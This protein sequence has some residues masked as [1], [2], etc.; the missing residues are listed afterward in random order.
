M[1]ENKDHSSQLK[2]KLLT[3]PEKIFDDAFKKSPLRFSAQ[4]REEIKSIFRLF[5]L[6]PLPILFFAVLG[7]LFFESVDSMA[8]AREV[9]ATNIFFRIVPLWLLN[10]F[11][12]LFNGQNFRYMIAPF[13]AVVIVIIGGAAYVQDIYQLPR[14]TDGLHYVISSMFSLL[15]PKLK[16]DEGEKKIPEEEINLLDAIGGPGYV[17]IQP[18]HAVMFRNLRQPSKVSMSQAYFMLP[19]ET[20]GQ[21]ANLDD[22]HGHLDE[23]ETITKD[24]IMVTLKDIEFR[25]RILTDVYT[26]SLSAPYPYSEKS[27][28]QMAYNLSVT[29]EG[30]KPWHKTVQGKVLGA[31]QSYVNSHE[32]DY[33]TAPKE[34]G[35]DPRRNLKMELFNRGIKASLKAVGAELLWIDV[36]HVVIN[37]SEVDE[38]RINLWAEDWIGNAE[39]TRA[40]GDATRLA[41]QE[42]GRAEAQAEMVMSIAHALE[43][44]PTT[45]NT[46][47]N[48]RKVF[49]LRTAQ[50]LDAMGKDQN[51]DKGK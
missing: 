13:T 19:F 32:I 44:L 23:L 15:Y 45:E 8:L 40:Y 20:I 48:M 12:F 39:A 37:D 4:N 47:E 41:Y 42:L 24:G 31:I 3:E 43:D 9:Q 21:V 50:I 22:Q 17:L 27:F 35:Q 11:T 28:R 34:E 38:S 46:T 16:I 49:L 1:A 7:D 30:P 51:G 6:F 36:G 10:I 5:I 18:G 29:D 26:R 14:Y 2:S 33:L 25:F